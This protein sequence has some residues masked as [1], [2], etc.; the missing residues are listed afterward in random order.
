MDKKT[1][2]AEKTVAAERQ[3]GAAEDKKEKN[4]VRQL[5][6]AVDWRNAQTYFALAKIALFAVMLVIE[7]FILIPQID[8]ARREGTYAGLALVCAA[9]L[10]LTAA[11]IVRL[12]ALKTFKAKLWCYVPEFAALFVLTAVTGSRF[13]STLYM[14]ILTDYYV[15]AEKMLPALLGCFVS[16]GVYVAT[17]WASGLIR[18]DGTGAWLL[19]QSF[20]DLVILIVHFIA[21]MFGVRFYRQSVRLSE[22][23]RRL[24]ESNNRLEKA[25]ANLAEVT[26]LEER[27]RIAKDIHDTAG[28]SITTVIMQTE[29]AKLTI[30]KDSAAAKRSIVAANL[31]AKHALE[32]LRES[33]HLLSG[34]TENATL[35]EALISI[36][37]ESSDG[38]G[39]TIR[40]DID[41]IE[42]SPAKYRFLCNSLKE[43]ISNGLRHGGATAFYFELKEE[44]AEKPAAVGAEFADGAADCGA[45]GDIA[46]GGAANGGVSKGGARRWIKF[47]LSDNGAGAKQPIK[48]GF[49]LSGMRERAERFG[50]ETEFACEE[51]GGFEIS[52]RIPADVKGDNAL[53]GD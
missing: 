42:V 11:E 50:G 47:L 32:E 29:A 10:V 38:T 36:I 51:D 19:A 23:L 34:A 41:D 2:N 5:L 13:L 9:I 35:A 7:S 46:C 48:T 3:S 16:L 4:A 40:S 22:T 37:H 12:C 52:M 49:G 27:Q 8:S 39:V 17:F 26:V 31:Q 44:D 14:I 18:G 6:D 45:G 43:G 25:Y 20:N 1:K 53:K 24:D 15:S 21:V 33:V 28:H 30:E